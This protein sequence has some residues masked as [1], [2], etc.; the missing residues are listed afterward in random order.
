MRRAPSLAAGA[1]GAQELE[2]CESLRR[3]LAAVFRGLALDW[4][5]LLG[6]SRRTRKCFHSS[7][8]NFRRNPAAICDFEPSPRSLGG[9]AG[10]ATVSR[11]R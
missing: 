11:L 10:L 3:P 1:G 7:S 8:S 4:D 9:S 2:S 6:T 5:H